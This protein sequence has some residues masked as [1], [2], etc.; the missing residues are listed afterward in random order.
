MW[1]DVKGQLSGNSCVLPYLFVICQMRRWISMIASG[2]TSTSPPELSRCF[3]GSFQSLCS[4]TDPSMTLW[5]PS[6]S[7]TVKIVPLSIFRLNPLPGVTTRWH[8]IH[9]FSLILLL[10][11]RV[12]WLQA[13][14]EFNQRFNQEVAK[15]QP[16][17]NANP[18]QTPEEVSSAL[19]HFPFIHLINNFLRSWNL[20]NFITVFRSKRVI[21]QTC[22][23]LGFPIEV[24][25]S[26]N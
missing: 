12:L 6:V 15:A 2:R 23:L 9:V 16:W 24:G 26:L 22:S 7:Y 25:Y 19:G 20:W 17:H 14:S 8:C 13:A 4:H 11:F 1:C 3:S 18:L 10:L 5:M 21:S